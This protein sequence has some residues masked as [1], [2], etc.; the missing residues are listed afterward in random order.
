[1]T[2]QAI[3]TKVLSTLGN[4]DSLFPIMIKDG[5]D[6]TSLTLKSFKEGG[7]VE[8]KDRF[9]DEFGTQ[10]IWIGGIPFFKSVFDHTAYKLAKINPLV[11]PRIIANEEYSKWATEHAKGIMSNNKNQTVKSALGDALKDGGKLA[12]NLFKGKVIVA[13]A[14]TLGAF[15]T[16]TK[17]KQK[18]TKDAT[19]TEM[20]TIKQHSVE[21]NNSYSYFHNEK[22]K[23]F[24]DIE[25]FYKPNQPKTQSFTG[26]FQAI[27]DAIMFNPVHNMKIIDAGITT[28]RLACSRNFTE[29]VEHA[30]KEGVF[31]FFIYKFGDLIESG[32]NKLSENILHK[33][34]DLKIDVLMDKELN[35]ALSSGKIAQEV[36]KMPEAGKSL[37]EKLNFLIQ[38]PDNIL[39]KAAKKSGIISM[40][41]DQEN[42]LFVDTSKY[43]DV[44][45][46]ETLA[47]NLLNI[48][49]N[50]KISG[51][52]ADKFLAKVK[53][54]KVLST[55][56]N[57][58]ISCFV[59]GYVI[60][61]LIY[62]YREWKTGST[63]FHV[64][65]DIKNKYNNDNKKDI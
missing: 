46:I 5:V 37:T 3:T 26:K 36:A 33:P 8:G 53:G 19:I 6:S 25:N 43:I 30:I 9:I 63:K 13:T 55:T 38:N 48:D 40:V 20:Q 60:P 39:V 59:L 57:I 62:K 22:S 50:Y 28:E 23:I 64:A 35:K 47:K 31:L 51:Q 11:D 24:D 15:F 58:A 34:I 45:E 54:L 4:K 32:I 52:S 18:T 14:L 42:N 29:F 12:K 49:K 7:P 16:L 17:Y 61:K 56:A 1:M 21:K 44:K 10:A 2:I 41:K 27:A 65:E